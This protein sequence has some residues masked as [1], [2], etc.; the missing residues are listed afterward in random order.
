ME[1]FIFLSF[2][3]LNFQINM[4]LL[5]K[6]L[7]ACKAIPI[8]RPAEKCREAFNRKFTSSTATSVKSVASSL[9]YNVSIALFLIC[10]T[11]YIMEK[12]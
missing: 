10:F 6:C 7:A 4:S 5:D 3:I 1:I 9:N 8:D 12:R 11:L 2:I